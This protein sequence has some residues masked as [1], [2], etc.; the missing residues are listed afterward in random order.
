[1]SSSIPVAKRPVSPG[2]ASTVPS[3]SPGANARSFARR[4][5]RL[6]ITGVGLS[7]LLALAWLLATT[8]GLIP[9]PDG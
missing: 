5:L 7:V 3:N 8:T 4:R 2:G 6:G 9:L 1:M